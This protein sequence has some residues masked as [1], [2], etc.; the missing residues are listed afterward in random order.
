MTD[1]HTFMITSLSQFDRQAKCHHDIRDH[2]YTMV[3]QFELQHQENI[4]SKLDSQYVGSYNSWWN[5]MKNTL[6]KQAQ[7]HDYLG[8]QLIAA[9]TAYGS[10]D[11][12]IDQLFH[13]M[14]NPS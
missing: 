14:E 2:L 13:N 3:G 12:E 9:K 10:T 5:N 1:D 11:G 6:I 4:A 7:L 8:N